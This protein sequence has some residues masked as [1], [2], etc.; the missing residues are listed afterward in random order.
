MLKL[1]LMDEDKIQARRRQQDEDATAK[2]ATILGLRYLDTREI[3]DS[4]PLARN[5]MNVQDMY[6]GFLAPLQS[7]DPEVGAPWRVM[8]TSQTPSSLTQYL[9]KT[10]NDRGENIEFFL[11]S[12]S[13]W[14]KIMNRYDPPRE[15]IYDDIEI[16]GEGDSETL[17]AVS[18]TL[19]SVATDKIFDFLIDYHLA[20]S[21]TIKVHR[22]INTHFIQEV[23]Q[24]SQAHPNTL[25][26]PTIHYNQPNRTIFHLSNRSPWCPPHRDIAWKGFLFRSHIYFTIF[27]QARAS[28]NHVGSSIPFRIDQMLYSDLVAWHQVANHILFLTMSRKN[29]IAF[30]NQTIFRFSFNNLSFG[31]S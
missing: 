1:E 15:I 4:F 14:R 24:L 21:T 6:K 16:A 2:R 22:I 10:Y 20:R 12:N 9:L 17:A 3:E 30:V 28:T 8:I 23:R 26:R 25:P 27:N 13:A 19:S 5:M 11:I 18:Q 7:G 31:N 29:P